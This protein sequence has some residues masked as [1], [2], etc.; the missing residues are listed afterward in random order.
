[1]K[2]HLLIKSP[3]LQ[4]TLQG[5]LR[6]YLSEFDECEF[7]ITDDIECE[8]GKPI[9][10]ISFNENA[11]ILRPIYKE[12]LM[13]D[14]AKFNANLKE[15]ARLDMGKFDN[16]LDLGE[17]SRIRQSLDLINGVA[18]SAP[19]HEKSEIKQEIERE[20]EQIVQDFKT[21]LYGILSQ[22]LGEN[23][24]K[25]AESS[26]D[27]ADST[28]E[29]NSTIA[30]EF[31]GFCEASDKDKTKV[32]RGSEPMQSLKSRCESKF[33]FYDELRTVRSIISFTLAG[34]EPEVI[35]FGII[36]SLVDYLILIF[37]DAQNQFGTKNIA[38]AGDMF[39]NKVFFDKITKKI[40]AD[41]KL[42]FPKYLDISSA[43]RASCKT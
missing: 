2:I 15:I 39:A 23:S 11:D 42:I 7:V 18:D 9:C 1:M 24:D 26:L 40:P 17:L 33:A 32:Y 41:F 29:A 36:E 43:Q 20:I 4:S 3:L 10:L 30:D 12:N 27:S 28:Q 6:D 16:I 13:R 22:N 35:A 31:L 5:Y 38:I 19:K 25:I 37:R 34:T 21:R 14:L 8:A